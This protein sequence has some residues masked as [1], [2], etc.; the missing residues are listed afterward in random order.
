VIHHAT[1]A[2]HRE[3]EDADERDADQ[4]QDLIPPPARPATHLPFE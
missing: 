3:A 4:H 2:R 1:D